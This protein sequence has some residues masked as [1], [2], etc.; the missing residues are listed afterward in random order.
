MQTAGGDMSGSSQANL[1]LLL[2][3][4]TT[5]T[6]TGDMLPVAPL[7][8]A[9]SLPR[10]A[11]DSSRALTPAQGAQNFCFSSCTNLAS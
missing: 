5:R 8:G 10:R 7:R 11:L 3:V 2:S 4:V 9:P 1:N 6:T